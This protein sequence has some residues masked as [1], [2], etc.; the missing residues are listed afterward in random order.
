MS[1][2]VTGVESGEDEGVLEEATGFGASWF[3]VEITWKE[4][5]NYN[6]E[7]RTRLLARIFFVIKR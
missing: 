6:R 1:R 4:Q 2:Y 7:G 5:N 3:V